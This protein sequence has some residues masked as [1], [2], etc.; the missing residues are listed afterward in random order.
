MTDRNSPY[1]PDRNPLL[2]ERVDNP[3][4]EEDHKIANQVKRGDRLAETYWKQRGSWGLR[5]VLAGAIVI[6]LLALLNQCGLSPFG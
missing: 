6:G 5:G 4:T 2:V 1:D 3:I